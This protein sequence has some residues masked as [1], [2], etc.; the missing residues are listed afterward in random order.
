[1]LVYGWDRC[2]GHGV[3]WNHLVPRSDPSVHHCVALAGAPFLPI[4]C[5]QWSVVPIDVVL[6]QQVASDGDLGQDPKLHHKSGSSRKGRMQTHVSHG[7]KFVETILITGTLFSIPSQFD[8]YVMFILYS[9]G[10]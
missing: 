2:L 10:N 7:D 6:S 9:A 4:Q 1:M 3:V 5:L 8:G